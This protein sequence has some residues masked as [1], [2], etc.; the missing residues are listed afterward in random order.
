MKNNNT[1]KVIGGL[2]K[3]QRLQMASYDTTRSSKAILKESLF[4]TLMPVI[5]NFGFI[6]VFAGTGSI[7]IE[8]LSRGALEANFI[9]KDKQAFEILNQNLQKIYHKFPTLKFKSFFGDSFEL[10]PQIIKNSKLK[11]FILFFDPPFPIRENFADIYMKCF[12]LVE[13][14]QNKDST[15]LV[16]FEFYTS[17][18]M[19]KNIKDFSII[20]T[21]RF[22]KSGLAYYANKEL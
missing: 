22:G 15:F 4:N 1:I 16:I 3:N 13:K 2:L 9:E 21:K 10:L 6:E 8:A 17:Y 20:K 12:N 18:E 7:G 14:I 19:P 5:T 11:N